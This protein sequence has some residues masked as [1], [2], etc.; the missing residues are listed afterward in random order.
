MSTIAA[1]E[2]IRLSD[3]EFNAKSGVHVP[4]G[5]SRGFNYA[6][7]AERYLLDGLLSIKD[8]SVGSD[9]VQ[10][11]MKDWPSR[12]HL[13]PYRSTILDAL[14]L[15]HLDRAR[16][17]ELGA[18]CGAITR[19]LGETGADVHA[20][21]GSAHR[22]AVA[23]AR[24]ADLENVSL[25]SANYSGLDEHD[26][27]DL[28]TLIGVLEYSHLYHS[29]YRGQ[30]E[31]AAVANL[32]TAAQAL[33]DN[34]VLVIAIE[35][36]MGLKYLNGAHED[37]SGRLFEG[38]QGYPFPGS[39][40]TFNERRLRAMCAEAGFDHVE[41]LVPYPDYKLACQVI[42]PARVQDDDCIYNWM[43]A[44]APGRG[45]ARQ[46]TRY[47]ETLAIR[48]AVQA[49]LLT[50][51]A[52]SHLAL[53]F[54]GDPQAACE[55]LGLDLDWSARHYSLDRRPGLRK[56][57]TLVDGVIKADAHPLGEDPVEAE[58][59]R[60]AMGTYGLHYELDDE[61]QSR[62]DLLLYSI[63]EALVAEGIGP[64]FEAHVSGFRHWLIATL[65]VGDADADVP[66]VGGEAFDATWWNVVV[67]P[68]TGEWQLI[69]KEWRL[70]LP[71]PAD[72]I[73][74]RM[75]LWFFRGQRV[76]VPA[77]RDIAVDELVAR[78]L[79]AA[80]VILSEETL[81]IFDAAEKA[82]VRCTF[83]GAPL[84]ALSPELETLAG[85]GAAPRTFSVV[86][87]ADE[88]IANPSLL[89]AYAGQFAASDRATLVLYAPDADEVQ[90]ASA[91]EAA[92]HTAGL[93]DDAPDLMLLAVEGGEDTER[94]VA[95]GAN[96]V[97]S[98]REA[99]GPFALLPRA[100]RDRAYELRP[101]AEALWAAA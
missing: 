32:V 69:D 37:H 16:V 45:P 2:G 14:E 25:Y 60:V 40:T 89:A 22:A 94:L 92:M 86:A 70:A 56:R 13:S 10:P 73:L 54:V 58:A 42:N 91:V 66:M 57:I 36:R 11:L 77:I 30:P 84:D 47:N 83:P 48:E 39:V 34:G 85:L 90:T 15:S 46:P 62:G 1:P 18:G 26:S 99:T 98:D 74:W 19:W 24:T 28:V 43:S 8:R 75:L 88:V 31:R 72:Y 35:N 9:Q 59:T 96:A 82:L 50:E 4:P 101:Y 29:L 7:G 95:D 81:A 38:I 64:R 44:V 87:F 3:F 67:E 41:V 21:E 53:A 33:R 27:F 6:D 52:N 100:G 68:Q 78:G 97:Y 63:L 80:G 51:L 5:E 49:G 61:P 76:Q 93:D 23:R 12:Y 65:G 79:A 17:L 20:I 71:V 55:R